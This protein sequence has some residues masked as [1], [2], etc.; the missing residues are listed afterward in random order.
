M[1]A[2]NPPVQSVHN[3]PPW[4]QRPPDR[5]NRKKVRRSL[6]QARPLAARRNSRAGSILFARDRSSWSW[7]AAAIGLEAWRACK[8]QSAIHR[9]EMPHGRKEPRLPHA[10]E[11]QRPAAISFRRQPHKTNGGRES[12]RTLRPPR[13]FQSS[14]P[15][16]TDYLPSFASV[17]LLVSRG[18]RRGGFF[19]L[20]E[21][22]LV[23]FAVDLGLGEGR[24]DRQH[25]AELRS[26]AS[27]AASPDRSPRSRTFR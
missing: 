24:L 5:V 2:R 17:L 9:N 16:L 18:V 4:C 14:R 25:F 6:D 27:S 22:L 12:T 20:V 3:S 13:D 19:R 21:D 10:R 8:E 23:D 7:Q 15:P 1:P 26:S 11:A